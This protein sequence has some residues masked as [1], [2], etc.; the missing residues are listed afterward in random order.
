MPLTRLVN[1]KPMSPR[2]L[3]LMAVACGVSVANPYFSQP[4]LGSFAG[5][6]HAPA[7]QIGLIATAAQVGYGT[8]LFFFL[9]LGDLLERRRLIVWLVNACAVCL[10]G[11][12]LSPTL[13]LLILTQLLVALTAISPQIL[14]PLG[15]EMVPANQ[16]GKLVGTLMSGLLCGILLARVVAGVVAD[17]FG[18]RTLYWGAAVAMLALG[19][20]LRL[21]LPR[22]EPTNRMSYRQLMQSLVGL[23]REQPIL[24]TAAVGGGLS[25]ACFTAFW[26][27]LSFLMVE[28]FHRGATEAGLFG[29][30]GLIGAAGAPAAGRLSDRKG[31]GFTVAAALILTAA[32]FALMW[33]WVTIL[34]LVIGVLVMDLGVQS[35][36]VAA[37]AKVLSLIPNA[38]SRL[39]TVYM[40]TRFV[41]GAFGATFG[42]FAWSLARWPGVCGLCLLLMGFALLFHFGSLRGSP[43]VERQL[44]A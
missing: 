13:P 38:R 5:Y 37:Q 14:I 9:P 15:S 29:I 44:A 6:F 42:A 43:T 32:S 7:W 2:L 41:G 16:R 18:W 24:R 8:G 21:A 3:G 39:N 19:V 31:F 22:Q 23:W 11:M 27:C 34:G 40:V 30:V 4:L 36:Q 33:M 25:F 17:H 20:S 35:V 10:V 26:T 12:A 1:S 28:R